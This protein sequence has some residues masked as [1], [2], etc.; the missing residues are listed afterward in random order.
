MNFHNL[1]LR[2]KFILLFVVVFTFAGVV[3]GY[4]LNN[5][6]T[7]QTVAQEIDDLV[8]GRRVRIRNV[9]DSLNALNQQVSVAIATFDNQESNVARIKSLSV[10]NFRLAQNY[11]YKLVLDKN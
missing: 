8:N 1:K 6:Y 10:P 2:H 5:I 4:S 9:G 3:I 7:A 11:W